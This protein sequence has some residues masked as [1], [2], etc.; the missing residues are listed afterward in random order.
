MLF[1]LFLPSEILSFE[2]SKL[3]VLETVTSACVAESRERI[4]AGK[5][6]E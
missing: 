5:L 6:T 4:G 2:V 1:A 3:A